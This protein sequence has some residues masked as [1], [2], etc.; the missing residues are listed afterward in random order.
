[1]K[2]W[3]AKFFAGMAES[4]R[5]WAVQLV[6][7]AEKSLPGATAAEKRAWVVS[8]LDDMVKLPW[9]AEP[10]DGPAFGMLVDLVCGKLNL[11]TDH[12]LEAVP[13]TVEGVKK[14]AALIDVDDNEIKSVSGM[15]VDERIEALY[16]KYGIK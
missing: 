3:F 1:M 11:L 14:A 7:D 13:L 2:E 16:R 4:L 8:R 15:S 6:V 12:K 10:F 9:Y 5:V